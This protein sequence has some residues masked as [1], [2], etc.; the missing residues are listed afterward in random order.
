MSEP[1]YQLGWG[2]VGEIGERS[3]AHPVCEIESISTLPMAL[4]FLNDDGEQPMA[5]RKQEVAVF[6]NAAGIDIG[7]TSHWV[8]VPPHL[9][10]D[11]VREFGP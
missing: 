8:A 7:A 5:A 4:P 1:V 11:P 9:A 3:S 6:P 2:I 10:E